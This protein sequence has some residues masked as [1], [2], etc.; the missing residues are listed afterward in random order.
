MP[1]PVNCADASPDGRWLA[2]V[3]DSMTV[4][5]LP[6]ALDYNPRSAMGLNFYSTCDADFGDFIPEQ[7]AAP[8]YAPPPPLCCCVD[9]GF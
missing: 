3:G 8:V 9:L 5:L 4:L 7:C 2:V 6:A 1:F